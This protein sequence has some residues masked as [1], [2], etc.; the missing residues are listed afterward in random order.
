MSNRYKVWDFGWN[1]DCKTRSNFS[2]DESNSLTVYFC[3]AL[4]FLVEDSVMI[5]E[6]LVFESQ[7]SWFPNLRHRKKGRKVAIT[8]DWKTK[9]LDFGF[10]DFCR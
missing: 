8:P 9:V 7:Y 1:H 5:G 3:I 6:T 4:P 10:D 2:E